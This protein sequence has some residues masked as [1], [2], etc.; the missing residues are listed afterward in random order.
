LEKVLG[1]KIQGV[2][3]TPI[4]IKIILLFVV[5][6]LLSNFIS[7]FINLTL[8]RTE[9]IK[10]TT[11]LLVRD[12]KDLYMFAN[13]QHKLYQQIQ[14]DVDVYTQQMADYARLEFKGT[15]S[16]ALAFDEQGKILFL[17]GP[18]KGQSTFTDT[19][20][21][22]KAVKDL[23][24][25]ITD[26]SLEF[27]WNGE[28]YFGIYRFNQDWNTVM[29]R[30]EEWNEFYEPSVRTFTSVSLI[31]LGLTLVSVVIGILLIRY[32]LR[33]VNRITDSIM[34]MQETQTMDIIDMKGAPN[35]DV[36][37][38]GIAMN[39]LSSTIQNL[40]NIFKKFVARDIAHKA[41]VEREI[42][43]EGSKREL[44][45]LFSDIKSFTNMTETLGTDIIKLL[46]IHYNRAIQRIHQANG[47]VGSIIGDAILAI[48]GVMESNGENKS[49][50]AIKA[51]YDVLG[52]TAKL[53]NEMEKRQEELLKSQGFLTL[54]EQKVYEAVRLEVGVGIDGG[55]VFYGNIGS[56]ERMVNTVIGDNV[57]SASRLEGLTRVY[58]VPMIVSEYIKNDALSAS[59]EYFFLELDQVQVKG[60]T[61]GKRVFYPLPANKLDSER[62]SECEKYAAALQAYYKGDWVAALAGFEA[63]GLPPARIFEER[64]RNRQAVPKDWN[65]VWTMTEK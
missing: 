4:S 22:D 62:L 3:V 43:L 47:D 6:L 9:Q 64:I 40:L 59:D 49:Y 30:A 14:S 56:N 42:R 17:A 8:N 29:V 52:E 57:N 33:F 60:K 13:N 32:I 16:L 46:N 18:G 23:R 11:T 15:K 20:A 61:V 44:A 26:G 35:D 65:G 28:R 38:L 53:R 50:Q 12:L 36:S 63:I 10:L 34:A 48:F 39:S 24:S 58:R 54:K 41:Y 19:V 51:G 55:E 37:Y 5:F 45:I 7:N 1:T 21:L 2:R 31:I 25:G 27:T